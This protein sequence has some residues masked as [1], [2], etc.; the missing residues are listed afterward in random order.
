M[1]E[2]ADV[3]GCFTVDVTEETEIYRGL[4]TLIKNPE[5]II[6]LKRDIQ[7]M[8]LSTWTEYG[9]QILQELITN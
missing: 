5:I 7:K 6:Q 2:V 1:A 9:D 3:G 8:S 4:D